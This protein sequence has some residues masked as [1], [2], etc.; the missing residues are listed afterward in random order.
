MNNND[1]KTMWSALPIV[2]AT[3]LFCCVLWGSATPAIKI[4][5]ELF[6]ISPDDTASRIMLAG[7]RFVLAGFMTIAFG[8]LLS[9]EL[10]VPAR[11]SIKYIVILVL[12]QTIG[13]YYFFFMSLA[14]TTGVRGSVINAS[15]NFCFTVF[16][17]LFFM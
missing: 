9:K 3:A 16:N 7:A 5:Y 8:S 1:K 15:G 4:A 11:E 14:H 2:F 6:N 10:L 12:F 17:K 13:Q